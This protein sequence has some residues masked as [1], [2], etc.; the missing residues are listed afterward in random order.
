MCDDDWDNSD[1]SVI[2]KQLGFSTSGSAVSFAG[3]GQ[4]NG[5]ILL[6]E[7]NCAANQLN[8]FNCPHNGFKNHDCTHSEDAG[9][10]CS[11]SRGELFSCSYV[12]TY[13]ILNMYVYVYIY[14]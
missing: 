11:D 9:V 2:C 6:D 14:V 1:A 13:S 5:T 10:R 3:F 12:H 4:G 8:I 7:V